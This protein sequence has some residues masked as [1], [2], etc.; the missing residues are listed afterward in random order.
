LFLKLTSALS[1][2]HFLL[3]SAVF[4][5]SPSEADEVAVMLTFDDKEDM[6]RRANNTM[7]GLFWRAVFAKQRWIRLYA[8]SLQQQ[9][10]AKRKA[11]KN[12]HKR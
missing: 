7:S 9:R 4:V 10:L 1:T 12:S 11:N 5:V 2:F 3:F 6:I 8:P